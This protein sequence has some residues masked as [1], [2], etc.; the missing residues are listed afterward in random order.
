MSDRDDVIDATRKSLIDWVVRNLD[1]HAVKYDIPALRAALMDWLTE[2][3]NADMIAESADK[4]MIRVANGTYDPVGEW[5]SDEVGNKMVELADNNHLR[6][7][8]TPDW[9]NANADRFLL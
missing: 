7:P 3:H 1:D 2:P 5:G 8:Y 6:L 4:Y 9:R